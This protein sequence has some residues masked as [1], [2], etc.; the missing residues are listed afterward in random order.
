MSKKVFLIQGFNSKPNGSWR[1]WL[2][3]KLAKE[4]G[5]YA[6]A[7]PMP[8]PDKPILKE[9]IQ[10][11]AREV[12]TSFSDIILVGHSLGVRAVAK[13]LET[14]NNTPIYGAILV[15]GRCFSVGRKENAYFYEP[16]NLEKI[17][18]SAKQFAVIH[19]DNDD[20]VPYQDAIDFSRELNCKLITISNGGHLSSLEG[21]YE[22]PEVYEAILKMLNK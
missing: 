14:L 10:T 6:C 21:F 8:T 15:S 9:W 17:K 16:L 7:L 4:H 3:G 11:I 22:L 18:K 12:G 5:I 13:Y 19:G 2:M 1:P 20:I